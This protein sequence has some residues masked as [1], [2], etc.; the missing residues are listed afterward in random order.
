MLRVPVLVTA[1]ACS[2]LHLLVSALICVLLGCA[3]HAL[4]GQE[5]LQVLRAADLDGVRVQLEQGLCAA[6]ACAAAPTPQHSTPGPS[7][8]LTAGTSHST[9][10]WLAAWN[11][12]AT[13]PLRLIH[14]SA[15]CTAV[16]SSR[17]P[18]QPQDVLAAACMSA[19]SVA[20]PEQH[21]A[22]IMPVPLMHGSSGGGAGAG[23][24][25]SSSSS[26]LVGGS[27][28]GKRGR[29]GGCSGSGLGRK[30]PKTEG[31]PLQQRA[32][33]KAREV[34]VV[35]AYLQ[36]CSLLRCMEEVGPE[37]ARCM[38]W[39]A[40]ERAGQ[41]GA[42]GRHGGSSSSGMLDAVELRVPDR[43]TAGSSA[44]DLACGGSEAGAVEQHQGLACSG[45]WA[46]AEEGLGLCGSASGH[47]LAAELLSLTP[48]LL[49]A[50][51][52]RQGAAGAAGAACSV[53]IVQPPGNPDS[54]PAARPACAARP[55]PALAA[56][57][58]QQQQQQLGSSPTC[59]PCPLTL[60]PSPPAPQLLPCLMGWLG[61]Q[62]RAC[63][64]HPRSPPAPT[65]PPTVCRAQS[66]A[67]QTTRTP[68]S[69]A[70][71][72]AHTDPAPS[73][74][75]ASPP[76]AAA[77]STRTESAPCQPPEPSFLFSPA[78]HQACL[79]SSLSAGLRPA[80]CQPAHPLPSF[81]P[82][83]HLRLAM[84]A[85][86]ACCCAC[87]HTHTRTHTQTSTHRRASMKADKRAGARAHGQVHECAKA[88]T[89]MNISTHTHAC[90]KAITPAS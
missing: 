89:H 60:L 86:E 74:R 77:Q 10:A 78:K 20:W 49:T 58:Q 66:S 50:S 42:S 1:S 40:E 84:P 80:A 87:T 35:C 39:C 8:A 7:P 2:T 83:G 27:G 88:C 26:K 34:M 11:A 76:K 31:R 28:R 68:S 75:L 22:S 57:R 56:Q 47:G 30:R 14:G 79:S 44:V 23:L 29:S 17:E 55:P 21:T 32:K 54:P 19:M 3:D 9:P 41:A 73:Q 13:G 15:R 70:A 53:H 85:G 5:P 69:F 18:D 4:Q 61:R 24:I 45:T 25:G 72:S 82:R 67:E 51:S 52:L 37:A 12:A 63:L 65:S 62:D 16:A 38:G 71:Q 64:A 43:A 46:A 48:S 81:R 33:S 36:P 90:A 6:A 59:C